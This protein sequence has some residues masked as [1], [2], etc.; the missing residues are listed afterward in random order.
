[1]ER[2]MLGVFVL[3]LLPVV[4]VQVADAACANSCSGHGRCG[5][6]NQCT[7]DADWALA[8]DCSLR[9]CP[10]GVAWTD[11]A[12]TANAAHAV[13]EC[14][15]RGVCDYSKGECTCFNGYTGA[16]CQR[17]RCPS[18]C[19]GHGLCYS[20]ATL[21]SQYG[22]SSLAGSGPTYT[23]WEKDSMT[24]CM[25]D[26][27][28]NGPDCSQFMCAKNDDPLT[29]GQAY[30]TIQIAVGADPTPATALAG[31]VRVHFLGDVAVFSAVAGADAAHE[32]ACAQAFQSMR[33][34][35]T[36]TCTIT[37]VD[38]V[39]KGAIYT[40]AF[41]EWVHLGGENNL[42]YHTGNPPL[43]SF[44]CDL[45]QVT[46]LNSP[47]CV[48]TDVAATNV[49]EHVYCSN[50]GLCDFSSGQCVCYTDFKG[51]DCNQPSNIPDS[52]DDNDGF[53]INPLGLAYTGTVL[54]LK[55]AKGSQADFYFMKIESSTLPILTMNGM[56]DTNLLNGDLQLSTGS[57]TITTIAQTSTAA[58]IANTHPTF[59]NTVLKVRAS[60]LLNTGFK[61]FEA[62]VGDTNTVVD[63]RGDGLTTI[64]TGGLSVVT[65]GGIIAN[66]V[67]APSLT[68]TNSFGTFSSSLLKLSTS[69]ATQY[70]GASDFLL[71]E[72]SAN[73]VPAFTV[74][75]S[76]RT[77][78]SN[79]GLIVS[80]LGGGQISN[81][82]TAASALVVSATSTSFVGDAVAIKTFSGSAHNMLKV[83]TRIAPAAPID[84]FTIA[85]S[86][87]TTI[88]QTG[89]YITSGGATVNA[90]GIHI[91]NGGETIDFGGLRVKDG[92]GTIELG[93]LN[94]IDGGGTIATTAATTDVLTVEATATTFSSN[95]RVLHINSK[96][97]VLPA[98]SMHY[99]LE[100]TVGATST[101]VFKVDAT[102]LATIAGQG[103]GGA[104]ISDKGTTANTLTLTNSAASFNQKVLG[105][106]AT[107]TNGYSFID[108]TVG[109]TSVY[110]VDAS[111]L[112]TIVG[113]GSGGASISD[114]STST[115]D[116]ITVANTAT[117]GFSGALLAMSSTSSDKLYKFIDA[118]VASV[119]VFKVAASGLATIAGQ[120]SG[121]A[122]ISDKGTTANTL[123]LT[124]SAASFNQ[125][126][127]GMVATDTNG[128]SF[129]DATVGSTSVFNVDASGLTTIV[130]QGSG[131]A[132]ISDSSTSTTDTITVANTA[133]TGFSG[134]LLAMSSTSSDKLYRFIDAQ[135]ASVSVFKVA[136][137][138]LTTIAGQGSGGASIFDKG[139]TAN[140]LS[141]ANSVTSGF[142]G[143]LLS[144][145]AVSSTT[146][147][148]LI[149]AKSSGTSRFKVAASGL[150]TISAG[151]L[152]VTGGVTVVD[153]GL[154]VTT[155]G[156]SISDSSASSTNTLTVANSATSGF[157]G[158]LLA[159]SSTSSTT[160]YSFID[161]KVG[162]T[163]VFKVA[164]TGLAT[165]AGQGSGGAS[166]SDTST[167]ANTLTVANSVSTG[168]TG[169][170]LSLNAVSST[171]VY[172]LIDATVGAG[173]TPRFNVAATG[174]TTIVGSGSGGASISDS[175]TTANTLSVANS[176]TS[177]FTGALLS[178]NAVSSTTSYTLIDAKSSGTSRF[179]VAASGLT[180]ISAG[181]L[182]VTGGVT[183]VDTGLTVTTG[184]A[185]L[186]DSGTTTNTLTVANSA[187]TGFTG[188][189]LAMSSTS[190]TTGY[191][192]IDGKVGSTSVFKV[193]GT[194]LATI[195]G[196][197][198]GGASVSDTGTT[199]NT[200]TVAN[201]VSTGFTGAVLS[202]NAVSS[203]T[204]YSLID[205]TVGA[206]STPRFNV[207]A[208]GLT[209]I[210]GSGSGGASISDSGTAT[211]T[212]SVANSVSTG[213]TGALLSMNAVS[214]T[215]AYTLIDAKSSGTSRFKVAASGLTTISAGGLS[216]TGGVTVVDTG[217]T[218]TTGGASLSDSG[219]TTNT[220]TVANSATTGFTG[221]LLA[222]SST[223][224][225]TGYSFIDGKVGST[226]VFKVG[227]TGLAT[228]A[229]QGSGGA[230]ISDTGTTANTLTVANSVSTGFTGTL[231]SMNAVSTTTSYTL[232]DAQASGTSKF[233][234]AASGLTTIA[235]GGLTVTTGGVT[236][237]AGGLVVSAGGATVT[238][239]GLTVSAGGASISDNQATVNTLSVANSVSTG[240]TGAL[241]SMNA[242]SSTTAYTLIDAKSSGTSR[243]KVAASG[244]T[245]ISA[246]GLSVTGG[247]T[248]VDTG[249]TVSAG[250]ASIA[251]GATIAGGVTV[252]NT[253]LTVTTGGAAITDTG[254]SA[255]TLTLTNSASSFNKAILA[256][257]STATTGFSV[258][259]AK[260]GSTSVFNVAPSGLT[261]I[262]AGGL[263][264]SGGATIAG[265]VTVSNTGLT[266][267]GGGATIAGGATITGSASISGGATMSGGVTVSGGGASITGGI[268]AVDTGVT[269][270]T[271]GARIY[272]TGTSAETLTVKN[273]ASGITKALLYLDS[274]A[275]SGFPLIDAKVAGTSQFTVTA[276][277]R[278]TI[279]SGGF[280]VS[281]G[282]A[283][284]T[285]G[286]LSVAG[287]GAT[288]AGGATITG[289][290]S[291]SGG[292]AI[293]GGVTVS[294]TGLTVTTGGAAIT[295]TGTSA[296][297]LTLTN[298]ASSFNKAILAM[299]S[300]ATTGFSVIDA[301]V[302]STSVFN[303]APSG[304]T[305]ISAGGLSVS[306]GATI[307]GGV[308]VSNTGLTVS[309]GGATIA[310]GVTV[311]NTGLTV[312][313]GGATIAGG[314]TVSN[315]GLTVSGGG[316][317]IA[318][319]AT[320]TGSASISGGASITGGIT[321]VDT[322]VTV[323]TGG[324]RIYDTG[325]SAE[326]LTVKNT[327][328][329]ITKALL[330]LDSTETSGFPLIDAKVAGTSQFTVT[331]AGLTAIASGGLSV[332]GGVTVVDTGVTVSAGVV[333]ISD[334]TASTVSTDGALVVSGG[335][336][337]GGSIRCAGTS[338]A[339]THTNT[340]DRRLKTAI[341]NLTAAQETIRRLRPVTYEWRR[342]EF[343]SR[344]FPTGVFPGFLADEVEQILPDL[345]QQDGDGWKS[346]DYVGIVPHLV[347]AVQ[348]MQDQLEA[349]QAQMTRMQQ[350]IDALLAAV[351]A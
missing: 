35:L 268:T 151:G 115:T 179:K 266:V 192:F 174:L 55:T 263:S 163:S 264:V 45:S 299:V 135:V 201:S 339:V 351:A 166:V 185:S 99:L 333:G 38:S 94:V 306:G 191:S 139:T 53:I 28:Y 230:S 207:A 279:A 80:G 172:S 308:T 116:T 79:G 140:T 236:I 154:T 322:G 341:K 41:T 25:C 86:G 203:T 88:T 343:P 313:G 258:I 317:T 288:I 312:S 44:T 271:G 260:V 65:G 217:L 251:G 273:T 152:S 58:D 314:V 33:T 21:A 131:G 232:I 51:M 311:S 137:S 220:L 208:T 224:S 297:T 142:T 188:A 112:T 250:G 225:T 57:L 302:G 141:V 145:N 248:V 98:T 81:S 318:G 350:Q 298:S 157:T 133:T 122:S 11:K 286:G 47:S 307:A 125:K 117:T 67:D 292:A 255:N 121:G 110:N 2:R 149:D 270:T 277:G 222:M 326:T 287:D 84:L 109:S 15:N 275:A 214:S 42:L 59:T 325:T 198:S 165:I 37:S 82:D 23:N 27:G 161:G 160:G 261:T 73:S 323:T 75:A 215:T 143:A 123:T 282:G 76:G 52:I 235:S 68:V 36:A 156:A 239:G 241:L 102:G 319:G 89:L 300:T 32:T 199:A 202:L 345:V 130:G 219:T 144:M 63:I 54:H 276:A 70:P 64:Y 167:T 316:A 195:A 285:A 60:R 295:D 162:S 107:D 169:A 289:S 17:L 31:S 114:S 128:Y 3:L 335:V 96:S 237:G 278:T 210:V 153:T 338:Y 104:S 6:S 348:E 49:I 293:A 245:T 69:R 204:V 212:L 168:F 320:I 315:T 324:A 46:S 269:V 290:A 330:Y 100:A 229:G 108:A 257:V 213:F 34:V 328:S 247:V 101:S 12:K 274:T 178:M 186:S 209:T 83:T 226:S 71:I 72:A 74:E 22:P 26:M 216:V 337:I 173:S 262:S 134:A 340:S 218:V 62:M 197:G 280:T 111:G 119:S 243:F 5:A 347:R 211:S 233:T 13:A 182:S 39:T 118:Q 19:S 187:T 20:S 159:M 283:V 106:V 249:L 334:T 9:K 194:G 155:G 1:M 181:G 177:G 344:N 124:N 294:N 284:I 221:A 29:T 183:V 303:V 234:V 310:G 346:M 50:R 253:G 97:T 332:K 150:T 301:K 126:V 228:I 14:S 231:L 66:T 321:A 246:G 56:G 304:L 18:D 196:Q 87:L 105:M 256:M 90:G 238:A 92:G 305:T 267:S 327:A 148:T 227:G 103:S 78:I 349:S 40:V 244:L 93:G 158:A 77:T 309:G 331:A 95:A 91:I 7:C 193:G 164:G 223:S 85:N 16:A 252:S 8:P 329:G 242:V 132:S 10:T 175:G 30:R 259:D 129:I 4:V 120:G 61:L 265:G 184:G 127:L 176:V 170:V 43:S 205:A 147:Y 180:T 146:S 190:S 206:G 24:S 281:A 171:T 48:V 189:L 138:G 200:L 136:A 240:F 291:I 296:N 342:D 254:T 272:D 113:Q 336:G